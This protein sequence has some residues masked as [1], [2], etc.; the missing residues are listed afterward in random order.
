MKLINYLFFTGNL[1][2]LF[3]MIA[4]FIQNG[5]LFSMGVAGLNLAGAI[6]NYKEIYNEN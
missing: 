6:V 4:L 1:I 5:D 2:F 3:L